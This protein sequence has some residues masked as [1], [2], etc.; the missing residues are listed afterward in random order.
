MNV[1]G[2]IRRCAGC[3]RVDSE[4]KKLLAAR[5]ASSDLFICDACV[6]DCARAIGDAP[7]RIPGVARSCSFCVKSEDY[8]AIMIAIGAKMICDECVDYHRGAME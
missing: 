8:V 4:V 2:Q 5:A 3:N 6:G 1:S 7:T